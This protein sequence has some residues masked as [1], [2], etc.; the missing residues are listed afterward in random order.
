VGCGCQALRAQG[1]RPDAVAGLRDGQHR[2]AARASYGPEICAQAANLVSGHH[3]PV[4][5]L[6]YS[7]VREE[8][9]RTDRGSAAIDSGAHPDEG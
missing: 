8:L 2:R 5:R 3:I 7:E 4:Y 9:P 1:A 6:G